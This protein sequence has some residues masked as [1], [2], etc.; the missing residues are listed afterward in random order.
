VFSVVLDDKKKITMKM[1]QFFAENVRA[2]L[3]EW[4]EPHVPIV[5][6]GRAIYAATYAPDVQ[7]PG[8]P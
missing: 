8:T 6:I 1:A 2:D 4:L 7:M 5:T 3:C